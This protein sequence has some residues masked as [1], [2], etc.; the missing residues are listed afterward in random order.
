MSK[1]LLLLLGN[2]V[3]FLGLHLMRFEAGFELVQNNEG[4][5]L[6]ILFLVLPRQEILCRK[7]IAFDKHPSMWQ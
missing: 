1:V 5:L 7:S 4:E 6:R 2:I 3:L